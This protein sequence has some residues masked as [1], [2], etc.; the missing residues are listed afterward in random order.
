MSR[1]I[2]R[3]AEHSSH[4]EGRTSRSQTIQLRCGADIDRPPGHPLVREGGG[5]SVAH[6]R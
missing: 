2:G 3:R 5:L 6:D 4:G 1:G